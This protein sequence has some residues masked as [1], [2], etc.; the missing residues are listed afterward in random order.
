M[1]MQTVQRP[2]SLHY[3]QVHEKAMR[4]ACQLCDDHSGLLGG[5]AL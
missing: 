4:S 5:T 3:R 1:R 2:A